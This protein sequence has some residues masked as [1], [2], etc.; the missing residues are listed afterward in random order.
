M[1][2]E[3][4]QGE[5]QQQLQHLRYRQQAVYL[6]GT[7]NVLTTLNNKLTTNSNITTGTISCGDIS[8][9][10]GLVSTFTATNVRATNRLYLGQSTSDVFTLLSLK[11]D[12]L[13]STD[14]NITTGTISSGNITGRNSTTISAPTV[15]ATTSLIVNETNVFTELGNKQGTLEAGTG[16]A[17]DT[18]TNTISATGGNSTI[19]AGDNLTITSDVIDVNQDIVSNFQTHW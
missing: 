7:T 5:H 17:V 16:I 3:I 19:T 18:T 12:I 11:Q 4:L 13:D 8:G 2:V 14:K 1:I 6:I 10:S 15:N 9:K